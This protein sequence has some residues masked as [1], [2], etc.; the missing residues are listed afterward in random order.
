MSLSEKLIKLRKNIRSNQTKIINSLKKHH[1]CSICIFCGVEDDLTKEHILPQWIYEK[2]PNKFFITNTN[3][4]SQKY[5]KSTVPCCVKCNNDIL[6]HLE[7]A[8][9]KI[10]QN[11]NIGQNEYTNEKIELIILWLEI[12][13]YK[14]QVMEIRRT[15]N[16]DTNSEYIPF[17]AKLPIALLQDLSLSP[18]KVFSN[19]RNSLK[20]IALKSKVDRLNSI[21]FAVTKNPDFNFM[22]SAN[23]FIFL[24][25]PKYNTAL[26]YF[27]NKEFETNKDS[28]IECK[29]IV[30]EVY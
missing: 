27:I 26:F 23:N 25:L 8:I 19:L 6:G 21:V 14:L 11:T 15:F 20:R 17:L 7:Y 22:H 29:K 4:S 1:T 18:S 9:K 10:F 28:L 12:I 3:G 2:N 16:K 13:A 30:D 5:H 24:E